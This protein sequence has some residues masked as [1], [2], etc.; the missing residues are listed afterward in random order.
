MNNNRNYVTENINLKQQIIDLKNANND[1]A[2]TIKAMKQELIEY[3]QLRD[4]F[5]ILYEENQELKREI[6]IKKDLITRWVDMCFAKNKENQE[7][8]D[9]LSKFEKP[10]LYMCRTRESKNYER[11]RLIELAAKLNVPIILEDI[12]TLKEKQKFENDSK[13]KIEYL[14]KEVIEE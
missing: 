3:N 1:K 9:K 8:K 7:L 14:E 5:K 10:I 13:H 6:V 11:M 12:E 2:E 4:R